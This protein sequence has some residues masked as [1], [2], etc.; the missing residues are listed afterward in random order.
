MQPP[1]HRCV[2]VY[3]YVPFIVSTRAT[4]SKYSESLC[5]R[6]LD[7]AGDE[8]F[9]RFAT[10]RGLY[11]LVTAS[12]ASADRLIDLTRECLLAC[13]LSRVNKSVLF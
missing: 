1:R 3:T 9:K 7:A 13:R 5:S 10:R 11:S 2:S 12:S 6:C 4:C 8:L